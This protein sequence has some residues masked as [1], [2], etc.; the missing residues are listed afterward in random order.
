MKK[1]DSLFNCCLHFTSARLSRIVTEMADDEFQTTGLSVSHAFLMMTIND[2]PG[3][4][5]MELGE[6]VHLA[7]ST[8]TRLA[9]KLESKELIERKT[10]GRNSNIYPT[11]KGKAKHKEI[12]KAWSSLNDRFGEK[13][14]KKRSEDFAAEMHRICEAFEK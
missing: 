9:D 4:T 5:P 8:V 14:G 1:C 13:L 6:R 12:L 10:S 3:I 7:P 11:E 2:N